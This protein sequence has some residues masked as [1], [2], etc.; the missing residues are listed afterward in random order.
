MPEIPTPKDLAEAADQLG[1]TS[2]TDDTSAATEDDTSGQGPAADEQQQETSTEQSNT[3]DDPEAS[4]EEST[5]TEDTT[6][7]QDPTDWKSQARKHEQR[8]K[9]HLRDLQAEQQK[10]AQLQARVEELEQAGLR[11]EVAVAKGV[12]AN[13]LK[14]RTREELEEEADALV[15]FAGNRRTGPVVP[16]AGHGNNGDPI[17]DEAQEALKALGF[18]Q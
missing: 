18:D 3:G 12:P 7:G 6:D 11:N 14:A 9:S 16:E 2:T 1:T 15:A 17:S 4:T 10:T 8:A 5:D 13:L